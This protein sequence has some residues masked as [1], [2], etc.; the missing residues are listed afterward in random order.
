ML[1]CFSC[2]QLC[3]TL[4]TVRPPGFSVHGILQVRILEWVAMP[5]SRGSSQPRDR[6]HISCV[7]CIGRQVLYHYCHLGNETLAAS[8]PSA[9]KRNQGSLKKWLILGQGQELYKINLDHLI[10]SE[11]KVVPKKKKKETIIHAFWG[12]CQGSIGANYKSAQWTK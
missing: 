2:V 8:T 5:S 4:W 7:S 3:V 6:T 1:S 12:E 10:V 11:S 9:N